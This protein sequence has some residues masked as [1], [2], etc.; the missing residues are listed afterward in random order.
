MYNLGYN[1]NLKTS[2]W[3]NYNNPDELENGI[4]RIAVDFSSDGVNWNT[5]GEFNL[6]QASGLNQ[7]EG[8]EGPDFGGV[9]AQYVLL[10]VLETYGGDCAA[11]SEVKIDV[12]ISLNTQDVE[13]TYCFDLTAHPN[14][15]NSFFN[16]DIISN[17]KG[18]A[19]I[20]VEDAMGRKIS[21]LSNQNNSYID[22]S[23]WDAGIYFIVAVAQNSRLRK[24]IVKI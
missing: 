18:E 24:R 10:T 15:F 8:E 4:S 20:W 12:D 13:P 6:E 14:P 3:W 22:A 9:Y 16:L 1:Y 23:N 5:W 17:C 19:S 2:H 7:Y 11:L 21:D